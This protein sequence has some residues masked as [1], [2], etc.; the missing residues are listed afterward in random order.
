MTGQPG[1]SPL[2]TTPYSGP[3]DYRDHAF[4]RGHSQR[5]SIAATVLRNPL[6]GSLSPGR[7]VPASRTAPH[8]VSPTAGLASRT[9]PPRDAHGFTYGEGRSQS[10]LSPAILSNLVGLASRSTSDLSNLRVPSPSL[11]IGAHS[12]PTPVDSSRGGQRWL[13][14]P[15][16]PEKPLKP[17]T[18]GPP[19]AVLGGPGGKTFDEMASASASASAAPSPVTRK[20][21]DDVEQVKPGSESAKKS[22]VGGEA[23]GKIVTVRLP[24]ERYSPPDS[25]AVRLPTLVERSAEDSDDAETRGEPPVHPIPPRRDAFPWPA[26]QIRLSATGTPLP[27]SPPAHDHAEDREGSLPSSYV[28]EAT[29]SGDSPRRAKET[30]VNLPDEVRGLLHQAGLS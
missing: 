15:Q 27:P 28:S 2:Y 26:H 24:P 10:S 17:R 12:E 1:G 29:E 6:A 21:S 16:R 23:K 19:K 8:L 3:S 9:P 4:G 30:R 7:D 20:S 25:P 11:S 13:S 5:A 22:T 18:G 14:L